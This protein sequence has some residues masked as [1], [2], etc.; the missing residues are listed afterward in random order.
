MENANTSSDI[1]LFFFLAYAAVLLVL[2]IIASHWTGKLVLYIQQKWPEKAEEFGCAS[3]SW[4]NPVQF[5]ISV[6][7]KSDCE[8]REFMRLKNKARSSLTWMFGALLFLFLLVVGFVVLAALF[9][10][11]R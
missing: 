6:Y 2:S 7:R 3:N 1:V 8:D 9:H 10:K 4:W 11:S 5:A